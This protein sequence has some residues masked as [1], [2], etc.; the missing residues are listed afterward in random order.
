[1]SRGG[2][3]LVIGATGDQGRPQV[4]QLVAAGYEVAAATRHPE[5]C[6]PLPPGA[7]VVSLDFTNP[8]TVVAAMQS[9]DVL[10]VTL[11]SSSFH[12]AAPLVGAAR[13][14]GRAAA[15]SGVRHIV[16]N[17]SMRV[18]DRPLGFDAHDVRLEMIHALGASGSPL[19]CIQPVI[20][21]GNLLRGWAWPHIA[22][23]D[24]FVYPHRADLEVCWICQE[25]VAAFMVEALAR[26]QLAG[27]R[28]TVGG[29]QV[30]RGPDVA[31]IL[32]RVTGREI[33]FESQPVDEFCARMR[34]VF[35]GVAT[36]EAERLVGE[37]GRI[38]R[39]YNEAP[40]RPFYVDMEPV[41]RELPVP[42]T[43]FEQWAA[44]Q[45]WSE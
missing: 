11:P 28:I 44:R 16:F 18:Y 5:R 26:P 20:Y 8:A 19:T 45:R 30:L 27:R 41:L 23:N 2:R 3:V 37:L 38:Y 35:D 13:T 14:L 36:L 40:E 29:P 42:L 32:S 39:W 33:V 10:F 9:I 7:T 12:A 4:A 34:R 31:A 6:E 22:R 24:R 25:D 15:E 21:M 17:T 1:M 43:S